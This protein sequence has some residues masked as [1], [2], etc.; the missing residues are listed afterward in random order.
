[1]S[2]HPTTEHPL[3]R[4]LLQRDLLSD[5]AVVGEFGEG[6]ARFTAATA[7]AVIAAEKLPAASVTASGPTTA[8]SV[9][10]TGGGGHTEGPSGQQRETAGSTK[11]DDSRGLAA[12]L[13]TVLKGLADVDEACVTGGEI[14][15]KRFFVCFMAF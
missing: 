11:E 2:H 5:K 15:W 13:S 1:M 14:D 4:Y 12:F 3:D 8:A 10:A 6:S 9:D 7:A